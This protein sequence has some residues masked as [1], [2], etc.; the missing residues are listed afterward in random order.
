MT[1]SYQI[2]SYNLLVHDEKSVQFHV[3]SDDYFGTLATILSLWQQKKEWPDTY[4]ELHDDLINLQKNYY[5]KK[6]TE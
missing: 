2:K 3:E 5:I 6:R 4:P 1:T